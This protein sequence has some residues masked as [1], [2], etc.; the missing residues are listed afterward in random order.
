MKIKIIVI[1][2]MAFGLGACA[3]VDGDFIRGEIGFWK[4]AM[5]GEPGAKFGML[6]SHKAPEASE[7]VEEK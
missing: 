5:A 1:V 6:V 7:V 2:L 4:P 3:P